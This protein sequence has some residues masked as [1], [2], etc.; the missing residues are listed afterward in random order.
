MHIHIVCICNTYMYGLRD[1]C[2]YTTALGSS[3]VHLKGTE[4]L[5]IPWRPPY[6]Y[7]H[8]YIHTYIHTSHI[9]ARIV[10]AVSALSI[11]FLFFS[12]LFFSFLF[13]SFLFS[14]L[15]FSSLS[16]P[17]GSVFGPNSRCRRHSQRSRGRERRESILHLSF[18]PIFFSFCFSLS[19]L[20]TIHPPIHSTI[21]FSSSFSRRFTLFFLPCL[22]S[23]FL[24]SFHACRKGVLGSCG[25]SC[26][27]TSLL[28]S[29]PN[30]NQ[31]SSC[32]ARGGYSRVIIAHKRAVHDS[33][34]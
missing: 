17:L 27:A 19:M 20:P 23:F 24:A 26:G 8:T 1:V 13:F 10:A 4:A 33:L 30:H 15:L 29:N 5:R 28:V 3:S 2:T 12:F 14:S 32:R 34:T 7:T 6:A 9:C 25:G 16:S 31:D 11:L 21:E 18:F 22:R